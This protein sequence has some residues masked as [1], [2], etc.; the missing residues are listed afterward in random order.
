ME[1][2]IKN[3]SLSVCNAVC[4]T[5]NIFNAE[6]DV[7]VP[8]VKPDILK[9]LQISAIP[10]VTGCET[11]TGRVSV[12]GTIIY[13]IL[14]LA[15]D[16]EKSVKAI[17][18][19]CEFSNVFRDDTIAENMLTFADVDLKDVSC[20]IANCR[21]L[22]MKAVLSMSLQVYSCYDIDLISDIEGACTKTEKLLSAKICAH[23]QSTSTLED[24]FSIGEGRAPIEEIL[25][26]AGT[27]SGTEIKIIDDKAVIKGNLRVTI[28]Y[29][30]KSKIEYAQTEVP[31][32]HIVEADG[33][34]EDMDTEYCVK[35]CSIDAS[36]A[37]SPN[38]ELCT[39]DFFAGLFFRVIARSTY[40]AKCV[41]DAFLPHGNLNCSNAHISVENIE[42]M[43]H[44]TAEIREKIILPDSLPPISSVCMVSVRPFIENCSPG[45]D[46]LRISGYAEVCLL[47]LSSDENSPV[48]SYKTN[49]DF[50]SA[51]DATDCMITPVSDC[52]LRNSD[53]TISSDNCIE[54][55]ATV[56]ISVE[57]V[58]S[59]GA[60]TV[61][62][63]EEG[64]YIPAARPSIII[65][66]IAQ[67]QSLWDIAK[68]YSIT[69]ES[70]LSAN[71]LS[72][73]DDI[74]THMTLI[75]PK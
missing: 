63:V 59:V 37:H 58:K 50:S 36:A 16:E 35:L 5:K 60:D 45:S 72:C 27:I 71:A 10:N 73:E 1:L 12:S 65:S 62:S 41:T 55:R 74:K 20:N 7:I 30:T 11:K 75:I 51:F 52:R 53:Y 3:E 28:L 68:E 44:R 18:S 6:C 46:A 2:N 47:Y 67:G 15:D 48:Y 32:A 42:S 49:V 39:I 4:R 13:N 54:V 64:E 57:C 34:R 56:E 29:K 38:G 14:Y 43:E 70:I 23:A 33:I 8:D 9:V 25:K 19:S 17:T 31:F 66:C 24:N 21:K 22:T 61:I 40:E 69:P 26:T